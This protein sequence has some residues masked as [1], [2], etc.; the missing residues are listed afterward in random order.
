[1][2]ENG[3]S[4]ADD[5]DGHSRFGAAR[6]PALVAALERAPFDVLV[7][8][9]GITG[10][11][12]ARDAA[13]RGLS[14][15]LV[16][17]EDFASGTSS[18]SSRLIHGGVR[19]LEH[20]ELHLVF[21]SS[22]E[23][24]VLRRIAPHLVQPL[25]FVWPVYEHARLPRWKLGLGLWLYDALAFF[26]NIA[27]HRRLSAR[28]VAAIEPALRQQDLLGGFSYYDAATDDIRL[29]V[30][31][32][33]AAA[34]AGATVVN[35]V[36]VRELRMHQGAVRGA[37]AVDTLSGRTLT[38]GAHVVVNATG[39]WSDSIRRLANPAAPPGVH[40][41]KG[42]HVAVPR[43]RIGNGG[44]L[45]LLSP[46]DGRVMFVLPAGLHTIIGT[47]DTDYTGPPETVHATS[48]DI[49]YLL[50]SAN[51]FF[52][53]AHLTS[54]D[55]V[56]AWAGIRPLVE[57]GARETGSVSRE[58]HIAWT[59]PGL[60]TI[61]GGKL[62]TYRVM[63]AQVVDAV[64]RT[65]DP[66]P[67]RRA[68]TGRVPLPGGRIASLE[69]ELQRARTATGRPALAE[70]L[71]R[72]YGTEWRVVWALVEENP[73]LATPVV[74]SHPDIVAE[75]L[76]AVQHEMALTLSD[77]L[78][79]RLHVAFET[80]DHGAA[81]APAAARVV[82]PLLDWSAEHIDAELA[83]YQRDVGRIFRLGGG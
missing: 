67:R 18:R 64:A 5:A 68:A 66:A 49:T 60:L 25:R 50:R 13:M 3:L 48:D 28:A 44:A 82:A 47:T 53:H 73:A 24:Y 80:H 31:N 22:H 45:T 69:E 61:T 19:Y 40:G 52:P 33:R 59:A 74:P 26:R 11:G 37:V 72:R 7:I 9:G 79:R 81:A 23:R 34:E 10:A 83:R 46:L 63:A 1:M 77:L 62:T 75:L 20:G 51:A 76:Y 56:S 17:R 41:T 15:A 65:T 2:T 4:E 32:A 78:I 14:V 55:V 16:E 43:D 12:I 36:E 27:R 8:G 35:H 38:I 39:P 30:A 21:E 70:H 42:V 54:A 71:V 6:R 57:S 58:H 29:T